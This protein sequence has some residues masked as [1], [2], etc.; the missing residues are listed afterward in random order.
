MLGVVRVDLKRDARNRRSREALEKLGVTFEG[1]LRSWSQSH[2]PGEEGLL[3]D[4]A[5]FSVIASEWPGVRDG[6]RRRLDQQ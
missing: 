1:V 6:L 4:S 2:A 5:M 3:R